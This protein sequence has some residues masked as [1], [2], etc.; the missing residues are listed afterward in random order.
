[1]FMC[2]VN[3]NI[4]QFISLIMRFH[5]TIVKFCINNYENRQPERGIGEFFNFRKTQQ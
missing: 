2:A 5:I 3:Y 1:M 4:Q